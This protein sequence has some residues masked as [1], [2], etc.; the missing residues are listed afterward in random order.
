MKKTLINYK[1]N[2]EFFYKKFID[3]C[4]S[5]IDKNQINIFKEICNFYPYEEHK[6]DYIE[7]TR[8]SC[9]K[10]KTPF[11]NFLITKGISPNSQNLNR[12]PFLYIAAEKNYQDLFIL[13]LDKGANPYL[14]FLCPV[15]STKKNTINIAKEKNNYNLLAVLI[16]KNF[17]FLEEINDSEASAI[18]NYFI[19]K[20][21][22]TMINKTLGKILFF[23]FSQVDEHG[24][25]ILMNAIITKQVDLSQLL[26]REGA[27]LC[28]YRNTNGKTA[29]DLAKSI[30][31]IVSYTNFYINIKKYSTLIKK[32]TE[33]TNFD[34]MIYIF[35]KSS[36]FPLV[37]K[38]LSFNRCSRFVFLFFASN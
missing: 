24:N 19:K 23:D 34:K 25:N 7:I 1:Q 15:S 38:Y 13:L 33:C 35:S 2:F 22:K 6:D 32:I 9:E 29:L 5:S 18:L 30:P 27:I 10:N 20:N 3:F 12:K 16:K 37:Y 17:S 4:I 11:V 28:C 14:N 21:D 36:R 31:Q 8:Y 26:I